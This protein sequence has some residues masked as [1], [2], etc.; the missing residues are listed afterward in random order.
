MKK[1]RLLLLDANVVI[2]MF[3]VGIWDQ[4][5]ERCDIWLSKIIVEDEAHFFIDE[6]ET[7]HDFDLNSYLEAGKINQFEVSTADLTAFLDRFSPVNLEKLDPGE[8]ESLAYLLNQPDEFLICSAD[9][10]I[11]RVLGN[12]QI[13]ERGVSLEEILQQNGLGRSLPHYFTKDY[14]ERWTRV[15]FQEHLS[16]I[17]LK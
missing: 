8:A 5:V 14:R 16:G 2:E 10:I 13:G 12:M 4:I 6:N 1:F 3:C 9:K 11:F 15:G 17:G 7:R